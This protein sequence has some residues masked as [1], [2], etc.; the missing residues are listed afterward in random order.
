M[1]YDGGFIM[2][3]AAI[4]REKNGTCSDYSERKQDRPEVK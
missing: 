1:D 4:K 3:K 2:Q